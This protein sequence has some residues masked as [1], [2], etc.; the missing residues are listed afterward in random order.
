M[1]VLKIYFYF[2]KFNN[3]YISTL[4]TV[5]KVEGKNNIKSLKNKKIFVYLVKWLILGYLL[6]TI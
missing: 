3:L 5:R 6:V 4:S 1:P 2:V